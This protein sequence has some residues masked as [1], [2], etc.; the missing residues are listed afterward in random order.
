MPT[1][2]YKN[3]SQNAGYHFSKHILPGS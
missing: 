1:T 2:K 3:L